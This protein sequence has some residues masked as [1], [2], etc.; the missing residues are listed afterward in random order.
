MNEG[1]HPIVCFASKG[2]EAGEGDA[3][4]LIVRP[5]L[6]AIITPTPPSS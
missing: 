1:L 2:R 3:G 6:F 4:G 5:F